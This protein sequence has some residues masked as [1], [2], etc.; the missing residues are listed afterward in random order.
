LPLHHEL[1]RLNL[2]KQFCGSCF[3]KERLNGNS[4][5]LCNRHQ[6]ASPWFS[7]GAADK[8]VYLWLFDGAFQLL[9]QGVWIGSAPRHQFDE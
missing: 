6:G 5:P 3:V 4:E 2:L 1:T 9:R 8:S 7:S